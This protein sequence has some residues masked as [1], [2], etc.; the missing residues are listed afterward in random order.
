MCVTAVIWYWKGQ[1]SGFQLVSLTMLGHLR[2]S[3]EQMGCNW[4][5]C[6]EILE[7][8]LQV[9]SSGKRAHLKILAWNFYCLEVFLVE[10]LNPDPVA[11]SLL[12]SL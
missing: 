8:R 5:S 1:C 10:T 2:N 3:G 11:N 4:L 12:A 7:I 9:K 6:Q